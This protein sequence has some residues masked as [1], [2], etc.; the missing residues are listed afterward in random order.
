MI[1]TGL[2][3]VSAANFPKIPGV[4]EVDEQAMEV[5]SDGSPSRAPA[6]SGE[7]V[8]I[9]MLPG[10]GNYNT[11]PNASFSKPFLTIRRGTKVT[12]VNTDDM[13]HFNHDDAG[14]EFETPMLK[15]GMRYSHVFNKPGVYHYSCIP[16]PWMKGTIA[17]K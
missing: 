13:V 17:V 7:E 16:H 12:F 11:D 4:V 1:P 3:G 10:A 15:T 6:S 2:T 8:I 14:K 5:A 9:K